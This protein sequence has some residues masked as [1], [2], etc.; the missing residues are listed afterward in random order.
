MANR[1]VLESVL[2]GGVPGRSKPTNTARLNYKVL[3]E[4]GDACSWLMILDDVSNALDK[5]ESVKPT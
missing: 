4:K 3:L 2:R 5:H 1:V